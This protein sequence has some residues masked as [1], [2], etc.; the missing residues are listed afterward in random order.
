MLYAVG[1]TIFEVDKEVIALLTLYTIRF[2]VDSC[3]PKDLR[4]FF[5]GPS[6]KKTQRD[7]YM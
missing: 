7:K 3:T 4:Q 5:K 6:C 2:T 1:N